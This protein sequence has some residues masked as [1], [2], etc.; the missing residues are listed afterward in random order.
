MSTSKKKKKK[1]ILILNMGDTVKLSKGRIGLVRFI[2]KTQFGLG[3]WIGIELYNEL[4]K[5]RHNGA[6]LGK[7][8]FRAP[9]HRGVFIRRQLIRENIPVRQIDPSIKNLRKKEKILK[10]KR[11]KLLKKQKNAKKQKNVNKKQTKLV[12]ERKKYSHLTDNEFQTKMD[13]KYTN[14]NTE[15]EEKK[16]DKNDKKEKEKK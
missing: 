15:K 12:K 1:A 14:N 8:Y 10:D 6:V 13:K 11:K 5:T 9:A 7:R 3:E 2:G 4:I 16:N